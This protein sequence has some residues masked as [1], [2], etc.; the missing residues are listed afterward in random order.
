MVD[1]PRIKLSRNKD[2]GQTGHFWRGTKKFF[3]SSMGAISP[4]RFKYPLN[5]VYILAFYQTIKD[6]TH[7]LN[8]MEILGPT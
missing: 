6:L 8:Q 1:P 2:I 4:S 3:P 5:A 7:I